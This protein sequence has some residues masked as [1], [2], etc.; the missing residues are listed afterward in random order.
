MFLLSRSWHL[1]LK[2]I[3]GHKNSFIH[4]VNSDGSLVRVF[5]FSFKF[6][7]NCL[8][9]NEMNRFLL[10]CVLKFKLVFID[11]EKNNQFFV[12]AL[13]KLMTNLK[14]LA[15]I[16]LDFVKRCY[17]HGIR[18]ENLSLSSYFTC[19]MPRDLINFNLV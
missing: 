11:L 18:I 10:Y 17:V 4:F 8:D 15:G 2:L 5:C 16:I 9:T 14:I 13:K 3:S 12:A 6:N 1:I 7:L 19:G